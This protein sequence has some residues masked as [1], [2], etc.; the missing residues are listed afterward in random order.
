[1]ASNY[2]QDTHQ[3]SVEDEFLK[4]LETNSESHR[5]GIDF[6]G[7]SLSVAQVSVYKVSAREILKERR[8]NLLVKK[9]LLWSAN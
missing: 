7:S 3:P 6:K 5:H 4:G 9:N 2:S 1:M 8:L